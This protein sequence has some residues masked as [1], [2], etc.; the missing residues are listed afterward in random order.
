MSM[1]KDQELRSRLAQ[2]D[3]HLQ[4][5]E[6]PEYLVAQ[7][8]KRPAKSLINP[9]SIRLGLGSTAVASVALVAALAL[10]AALTPDPLFTLGSGQANTMASAE[11]AGAVAS[12]AKM[13]M[14]WPGYVEYSYLTEDLSDE[15]GKG[16]IY[17]AQL[18][19]D[20]LEMM[21]KLQ[22]YFGIEG[23]AKRDEW[24]SD[25][26]PSFSIQTKNGSIESYLSVYWSGTGSWSYS[27]WDSSFWSCTES[28]SSEDGEGVS[29][30]KEPELT[31]ELIPTEDQMRNQAAELF[32]QF[33]LDLNPADFSIYRDDWGGS[34]Y[35]DLTLEG[36]SLPISVSVGWDARGNLSYASGHSFELVD[37]GE[38]AT[39]SA[40][41][42]VDRIKE[43]SWYGSPASS[44]YSNQAI[45]GAARSA[46][47]AT[48]EPAPAIEGDI[49]SDVVDP[50]VKPEDQGDV[51]IEE[52]MPQESVEPQIIDLTINKSES[53]MLGVWDANGGFWLVP[54]YLLYNDQGW[55]D[56]IISVEE[57][58]I[59]LP[60]YDDV[61]PLIEPAPATKED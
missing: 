24:S 16:H 19:G 54:G 56:S 53:V 4:A 61:M 2:S 39:I 10:P 49:S 28:S 59:E 20:P 52:P 22:T 26:Y 13:D 34:A 11:G 9:R 6:L 29:T 30:C 12:D 42:A 48:A 21:A 47:A 40:L 57:G 51:A 50:E 38:F 36:I 3:A 25:Q 8:A 55:F 33:G 5:P 15:A 14:I 31:P 35:A 32:G 1:E 43:G 27:Q 18:V 58:V 23:E 44:Y 37:R 41:D 17:Q 7:A 46:E 45:S 60:K